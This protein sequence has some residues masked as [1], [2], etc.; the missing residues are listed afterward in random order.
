[1]DFD[2]KH[3]YFYNNYNDYSQYF[4]G[5][6]NNPNENYRKWINNGAVV[7]NNY[8]KYLPVYYIPFR[9]GAGDNDYLNAVLNTNP[10]YK[11]NYTFSVNDYIKYDFKVNKVK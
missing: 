11:F 9:I 8:I 7:C 2:N 3:L 6:P 5:N 10:S 4:V 1:M